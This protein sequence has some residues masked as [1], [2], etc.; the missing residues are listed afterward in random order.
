MVLGGLRK[1]EKSK[2]VYIVLLVLAVSLI[3]GSLTNWTIIVFDRY[4]YL[5]YA[6]ISLYNAQT[7]HTPA[8]K[9]WYINE[10]IQLY[11]K[12]P[13]LEKI[14]LLK[15]DSRT[16]EFEEVIGSVV[17]EFHSKTLLVPRFVATGVLQ[18]LV[19]FFCFAG[20]FDNHKICWILSAS[21]RNIFYF[22][23][24]TLFIAALAI[25]FF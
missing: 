15:F 4:I 10:T 20:T 22:S 25:T 17:A 12:G 21:K 19:L 18:I 24:A 23:T 1:L 8:E 14:K 6:R 7:A 3:A 16:Q 5:D 13:N 2:A 9:T 11:Q